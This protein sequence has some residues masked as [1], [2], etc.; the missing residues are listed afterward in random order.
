MNEKSVK[1]FDKSVNKRAFLK[2]TNLYV[3]RN[4]F[5]SFR[6]LWSS[7]CVKTLIRLVDLPTTIPKAPKV[8]D[9]GL[10][11]NKGGCN[12]PIG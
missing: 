1:F 6:S 7:V 2:I 3:P 10:D 9:L 4:H 5:G 8:R 12:I 11:Q